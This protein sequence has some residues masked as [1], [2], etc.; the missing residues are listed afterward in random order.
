MATKQPLRRRLARLTGVIAALAFAGLTAAPAS[1]DRFDSYVA[2]GDSY[3]AGQGAGP[4]ADTCLRSD[5][6]YPALLDAVRKISLAGNAACSGATTSTVR[7]DQIPSLDKRVDLVTVTAGG[8]DL[9]S[10]GA[11]VICS[12]DSGQACTAALAQRAAV[13]QTALNTPAASP[14]FQD[15]LAMLND[16]KAKAP[17]ADIYV[18]GYPLLFEPFAGPAAGPINGLTQQL[19]AV[20]ATAA[21]QADGGRS[22]VNYVD[23]S[24]AFAGHGIG[25][26]QPWIVVP[27]QL[28][29]ASA[30]CGTPTDAFHPTADGYANGYAASIRAAF[31]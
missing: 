27:P 24:R 16:V 28:C 29:T 3:A 5:H 4:Y 31:R 7:A 15:L 20:I 18:T 26:A 30:A 14:F 22:K 6:G 8:N 11:L 21:R 10:I 13:L 17:R 2:L 19:N 12:Q 1:A 25:S 9:D 23:V